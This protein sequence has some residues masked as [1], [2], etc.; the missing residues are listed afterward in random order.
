MIPNKR[1][2]KA[3]VRVDGQ[4]R[5]VA[6]SLILRKKMP[7][8]GKWYEV[9]AYECCNA[10]TTTIT[11][12]AFVCVN[13]ITNGGFESW[14]GEGPSPW[15]NG[16]QES[17][18][19]HSGNYSVKIDHGSIFQYFYP[20]SFDCLTLD[21]WYYANGEGCAGFLLSRT[22]GEGYEYLQ[23][24]GSWGAPPYEHDLP[25]TDGWANIVQEF[26]TIDTSDQPHVLIFVSGRECDVYFDDVQI[27]DG[28]DPSVTTTT[29]TTIALCENPGCDSVMTV[30]VSYNGVT[31]GYE[32]GEG[33]F[34]TLD[35]NCD[36]VYILTWWANYLNLFITTCYSSITVQIDN[37][38]FEMEFQGAG[39]GYDYWMYTPLSNPFASVGETSVI[40]ICG[41]ECTT[42][43]TTS[44]TSTTSTTTTEVPT[45][46][47]TT[48]RI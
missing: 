11:T 7:K 47:T 31:F 15:S 37:Q 26:S 32:F 40:R 44:S 36:D 24:D 42:T 41:V 19:V 34:G 8:V 33:G 13:L 48:T 1:D 38:E 25:S 5:I 16:A 29:T 30:G 28:C 14:T 23:E 17:M 22:S 12:T 6:G 35:P 21:F 4:G 3:F 10:D 9:P 46:T 27:C 20:T 45:T 43:T 18:I 2:L 39:D